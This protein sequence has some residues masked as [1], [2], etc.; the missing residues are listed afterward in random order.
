MYREIDLSTWERR[1]TFQF[2]SPYDDPYFNVTGNLDVTALLAFCRDRGESFFHHCL[3]FSLKTANELEPFQLRISGEKV[4][5]YDR[6]HGGT[7]VLFDN[8]TFGFC[9]FEYLPER[10]ACVQH[11]AQRI[12]ELKSDPTH[13]P[14]SDA[15]DMI[16]YSVMPWVSF[17]GVKNPRR[18]GVEDSVPKIVFGKYFESDGKWLMPLSVEVHHALMD[19]YHVG[20]YFQLLQEEINLPLK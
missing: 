1:K 10:A 3:Y 2:F 9:Y 11:I 6:I 19:G 13:T 7:T 4:R 18:F 17:T 15:P 20:V 16:H 12:S 14:D 5:C 8:S